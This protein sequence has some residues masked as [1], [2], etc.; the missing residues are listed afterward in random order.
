MIKPTKNSLSFLH[1]HPV[2]LTPI[3]F[4]ALLA[5]CSNGSNDE[6]PNDA[7]NNAGNSVAAGSAFKHFSDWPSV[8]SM[9]KADSDIESQVSNI[10]DQM[11]LEEKVGQM[12][13]PNLDQVTPAEA[14]E[15]KLGSLLNGGGSWPNGNKRSSAG[16]WAATAD[17]YWTA[18]DE[19]YDGRG[20]K[21]PFMWATDAVHGHNNVFGATV[22][23]HNIGLGAAND[24]EMILRIGQATAKEVVATGLDWT[25]APTVAA[26]RDYRWGRVYEGYS[27]DPEII[28][29][30]AG[31]MVEGLQGDS[32][33]LKTDKQV[34]SNVKHWVGDG[35]TK[36][37]VDR[38]ETHYSE[39]YLMNIHAAG[40][41]SGLSAG[42]QVVMSSFNSWHDDANYDQ[43]GSGE[44]NKKL[45]GSKYLITDVLKGKLGFDGIVVTDW[46]GQG[47]INGC[48]A[49][50]CPAAVNAGN[51]IFMVTARVDWKPFYDNVIAQVND[52]TIEMSRID[53]AV[54][55]ILRVKMRAGLWDKPKPSER[56]LAGDDSVL[57]SP[58]HR[59][60]AREAVRKSLVLLK[61]NDNVLP[62][63]T[64]QKIYLAGSAANNLQKQTGGWS[65]TWQ[66]TEND[67]SDFPGATTLK[68]ALENHTGS[69]NIVTDLADTDADTIALVAIGESPYAEFVGDIKDHQTLGF[70]K[71]RTAYA[72]DLQTVKDLKATGMKVV[73][74]FFSG[75]PMY[76]NEEINNS[77]AFIA[78]WLPGTEAGGITDVLYQQDGADFTGRLSYS[79]PNKLCS[80]SINRV[81]TNIDGYV[82]PESEQDITGE[83]KP[84][85]AYGH[86]L[87]YTTA[88][89]LDPLDLDTRD[90]GCGR[91]APDDGV[92]SAPLEIYGK[93]SG[94][95][96][97]MRIGGADNGWQAIPVSTQNSTDQG[98]VSTNP[99]NYQGQYDA[100][101]VTF[102]GSNLAQIYTQTEDEAG[103]D[104]YSHLNA[105]STLQFDLR[106]YQQPT[107]NFILA[108]HCVHPC[109]AEVKLNDFLPAVS[110]EWTTL[111]VPLACFAENGLD[112]QNLNTSFLF[113]TGGEAQFDLG[114]IRMVPKSVDPAADALTCEQLAGVDAPALDEA[115]SNILGNPTWDA[116]VDTSTFQPTNEWIP[117][118]GFVTTNLTGSGAET[119]VSVVYSSEKPDTDKGVVSV[120]GALQNL[121]NY[122]ANG[123][124]K[125]DLYVEDYAQ[126]TRGIVIKM[127]SDSKNGPDIFLGSTFELPAGEWHSISVTFANLKLTE[128]GDDLIKEIT[129]P[130]VI[131][132]A[133]EESQVGV[134]F[135]F[136]NVRIVKE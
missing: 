109:L 23:P 70:A 54:T 61:N 10:L 35:G 101:N 119:E 16:D 75:R 28:Y 29:N 22:F 53:D 96:F 71:L 118:E 3:L 91:G 46:N 103:Q 67:I 40:Y 24:P 123:S 110:T 83:H 73:T 129:K 11:T 108:Q 122:L 63:N 49:A 39:E 78:A 127:E 42:A 52:G 18:V 62:L 94:G 34:L 4:A 37:G 117:S 27:E 15:Y 104:L 45:H 55:R 82:T 98:S 77:D 130:L 89:N 107:S 8:S 135:K 14:K 57:G 5:G 115:V 58:E 69:E 50:D 1:R 90:Y 131:L 26:P 84:L 132:P 13:Q 88:S 33:A 134:S 48:T 116:E 19:A 121:S 44:Y 126:N 51:D 2:K 76:V 99:I 113:F 133:W 36:K 100:V 105:E 72:A 9:I 102:N 92:A 64:T 47:E 79:W 114:N 65:L 7:N 25:F 20:F 120:R 112:F 41:F 124:L 12:I 30:Y 106:M 59:A 128:D 38:G 81:P 80:T 60:L 136:R 125:F 111:K 32:D 93:A 21:I 87:A 85:F 17:S 97:A 95:E 6:D 43:T 31:K 56:S 66:G 68:T 86:G 74:I